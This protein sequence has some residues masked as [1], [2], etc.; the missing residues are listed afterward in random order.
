MKAAPII[1]A[2]VT[3]APPGTPV[4]V[5][6]CLAKVPFRNS[7]LHGVEDL[8]RRR[9]WVS[10]GAF[11]D[12]PGVASPA[13]ERPARAKSLALASRGAAPD[14][15]APRYSMRWHGP[16][17]HAAL[18]IWQAGIGAWVS[19]PWNTADVGARLG[20]LRPVRARS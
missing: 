8:V 12:I 4:T 15:V 18:T 13:G 19:S 20:P 5:Y 17:E 16:D 9:R 2:S 14:V 10:V 6:A 7:A 11:I 1:E 3:G